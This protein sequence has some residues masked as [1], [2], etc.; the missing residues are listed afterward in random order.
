MNHSIIKTL[1]SMRHTYFKQLKYVA[2]LSPY[3]RASLLSHEYYID[4]PGLIDLV[5]NNV[6]RIE[7]SV[8]LYRHSSPQNNRF[9]SGNIHMDVSVALS[10]GE[11]YTIYVPAGSRVI[12]LMGISKEEEEVLLPR[13][14]VWDIGDKYSIDDI[15]Y[16]DYQVYTH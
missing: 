12:P 11:I 14:T 3:I 6:P 8:T 1:L 9:V 7:E 4:D 16:C 10:D 5:F 2:N 13:Y 15:I